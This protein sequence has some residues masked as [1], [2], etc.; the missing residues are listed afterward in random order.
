M[1]RDVL[2]TVL[3]DRLAERLGK[4]LGGHRAAGEP[5]SQ[6]DPGEAFLRGRGA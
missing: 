6:T 3:G 5:P 4:P 1:L 2:V